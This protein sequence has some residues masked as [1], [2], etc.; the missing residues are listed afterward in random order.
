M[1]TPSCFIGERYA[2]RHQC[3]EF[4][5]GTV[6]SQYLWSQDIIINCAYK[7]IIN[8]RYMHDIARLAWPYMIL[9]DMAWHGMRWHDVIYMILHHIGRTC[10]DTQQFLL[11]DLVTWNCFVL[12]IHYPRKLPA[13]IL[14]LFGMLRFYLSTACFPSG[15]NMLMRT[16]KHTH[17]I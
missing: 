15:R 17:N 7:N 11:A 9:H 14:T 5:S 16:K 12:T 8:W 1:L 13:N 2:S 10:S 3:R 6:S 4:W